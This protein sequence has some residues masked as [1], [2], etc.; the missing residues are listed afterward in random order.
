MPRDQDNA[1]LNWLTAQMTQA[2]VES[3]G[4]AERQIRSPSHSVRKAFARGICYEKTLT[5]HESVPDSPSPIPPTLPCSP[6]TAP[7]ETEARQMEDG[8]P[9]PLE[10]GGTTIAT[11]SSNSSE[12]YR[13][14]ATPKPISRPKATEVRPQELLKP[15]SSP[16]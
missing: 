12:K 11:L 13:T 3:D 4:E 16:P 15:C 6:P 2:S 10:S 7:E 8:E 14:R 5:H 1:E 9:A